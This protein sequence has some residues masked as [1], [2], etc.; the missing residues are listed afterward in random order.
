[1][2]SVLVMMLLPST[3]LTASG[4]ACSKRETLEEPS[5]CGRNSALRSRYCIEL[6]A[7]AV[8]R[9]TF[10]LFRPSECLLVRHPFGIYVF[11]IVLDAPNRNKPH[12]R[13]F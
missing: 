8:S 3:A 9:K 1:M 5:G 7:G 11:A 2:C 4:R 13:R 10:E 12:R 6:R